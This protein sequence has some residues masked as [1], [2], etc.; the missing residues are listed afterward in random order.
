MISLTQTMMARAARFTGLL[1]VMLGLAALLLTAMPAG[2]QVTGGG[3]F[4]IYAMSARN[5]VGVADAAVQVINAKGDV[6]A[7]GTTNA[8][9]AYKVDLPAGTYKVLVAA[10]GYVTYEAQFAVKV[11]GVAKLTASLLQSNSSLAAPVAEGTLVVKLTGPRPSSAPISAVVVVRTPEGVIVAQRKMNTDGT[12]SIALLPQTY[13][14]EV[15]PSGY[16]NVK[17]TVVVQSSQ[18]T[19]VLAPLKLVSSDR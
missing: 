4:S 13:Y 17:A 15:L 2:A 11:G 14:V 6:V 8:G 7:K 10:K 3:T 16:E 18:T 1:G 12:V 9:G 19:E 5:D